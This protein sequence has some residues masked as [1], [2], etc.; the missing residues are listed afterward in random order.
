MAADI[1]LELPA[2][3]GIE[4]VN[5]CNCRCIF[6]PLFQGTE[7]MLVSK[8]P[9]S[10]ME[11]S[12]FEK[13]IKEIASWGKKPET[14]Y[15][16]M[17]GEPFLDALVA[18]RLKILKNVGLS[19]QVNIQTNAQFMTE[20]ISEALIEAGVGFL[21][22]GFDG[23]SKEVYEKHRVGC[24]YENVLRNI[25]SF[26]HTRDKKNGSTRVSIQY[27]RTKLNAHEVAAAYDFFSGILDPSKDS[28]FDTISRRW[29]GDK[30]DFKSILLDSEIQSGYPG[31]CPSLDT[32]MIILVDGSV[33]ACCWDYNLSVFDG[34]L[35]NV[36]E[37]SLRE[38]WEGERFM[39]LRRVIRKGTLEEKPGKCLSCI[40]LYPR[41]KLS[42]DEALI[43]HKELIQIASEGGY[44]YSFKRR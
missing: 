40:K 24:D 7:P 20:R 41:M 18:E 13:I 11:M 39:G 8:R 21:T 28:F 19:P 15:L 35:G 38:V 14:I 42:I 43:S 22:I 34:P 33:A 26:V 12:L 3:V 1:K 9:P 4:T 30:S 32:Q 37:E 6:C 2:S 23:A 17:D 5:F 36:H 25:K 16:N 27:V 31:Y 10:T 44:V 29:G